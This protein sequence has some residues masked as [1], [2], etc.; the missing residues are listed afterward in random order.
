MLENWL[1]PTTVNLDKCT[2]YQFLKGIN[3]FKNSF[4]NLKDTKIALLGISSQEADHIRQ[5]LFQLSNPFVDLNIT[6]IG[7]LK[8]S[9][10]EFVFPVIK[11]LLD[12]NILPI[13][14]GNIP[15]VIK[16]QYLAHKDKMGP[17]NMVIVS[18]NLHHQPESNDPNF[19]L[20][21]IFSSKNPFHF[22]L[23]GYQRHFI[24]NENL[25]FLNE[26]TFDLLSLGQI[27]SKIEDTE[28][29]I[30]DADLVIFDIN[31]IRF[32]DASAQNNPSPTGLTLEDS[33]QLCRYAG[34]SDKLTSIGFYG[35]KNQ[36]DQNQQTAKGLALMIWYTIDGIAHRKQDFPVSTKGMTEYIVNIKSY[37]EEI[38]FWKSQKSGRWWIQ[39]PIKTKKQN[40]RHQL[41]P[42]SYDDYLVATNNELP[43]TLLF[44][45]RRFG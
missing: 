43:E 16:V 45:Y 12:A 5:E 44:A 29:I 24:S 15:E 19:Y 33:C 6:D 39:F 23:L 35:Y 20:N 25:N 17:I 14:L 40:T 1:E 41:I 26:N 28:P 21:E 27:H 30:R 42:C 4:P 8:K 2:K 11:E 7:N 34:M 32:A 9:N 13:I 18:N 22:G 3:I 31:A 38:T 37:D 10:P 36:L